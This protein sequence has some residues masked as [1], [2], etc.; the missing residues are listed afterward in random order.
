MSR[1]R[2]TKITLPT[3]QKHWIEDNEQGHDIIIWSDTG[4]I[5][6]EC[7]WPDKIRADDGRVKPIGGKW[8]TD[9]D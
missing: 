9:K 5:T 2:D 4:K 6:I 7:R 3:Y 1:T 8:E